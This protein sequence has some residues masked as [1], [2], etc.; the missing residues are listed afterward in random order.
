MEITNTN[1][2]DNGI[3]KF[4]LYDN[5][6]IK[7][8]PEN[9]YINTYIYEINEKEKKYKIYNELYE[10]FDYINFSCEPNIKLKNNF[11]HYVFGQLVE[12]YD[13]NKKFWEKGFFN[14][15]GEYL[16][17]SYII[18]FNKILETKTEHVDFLIKVNINNIRQLDDNNFI[19]PNEI[20]KHSTNKIG[21]IYGITIKN[22]TYNYNVKFSNSIVIS[23]QKNTITKIDSNQY[24]PYD[25]VLFKDDNEIL[26]EGIIFNVLI[27]DDNS[28]YN[29]M[30]IKDDFRI[31]YCK[32]ISQSNIIKFV[33]NYFIESNIA[34]IKYENLDNLKSNYV[35][36][37]INEKFFSNEHLFC[38]KKY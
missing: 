35:S 15:Y 33:K 25:I 22:N 37:L 17:T 11:S 20:V 10:K 32:N 4:N 24:F 19:K 36:N 8:D 18:P 13:N 27:D 30:K 31:G 34:N 2:V 9:I 6:E 21:R 1:D 3:N 28:L 5:I 29:I 26:S 38:E 14:K 23:C 7:L 12:Y 16:N